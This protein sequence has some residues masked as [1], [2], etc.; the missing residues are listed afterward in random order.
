MFEIPKEHLR[1]LIDEFAS[2]AKF[3]M[4]SDDEAA[5]T[6]KINAAVVEELKGK[7][8]FLPLT[9]VAEA[10]MS[11]SKGELGGTTR[12][13]FRNVYTWLKAV[14]EKNQ[15]LFAEEKSRKDDQIKADSERAF[16]QSQKRNS[17]YGTAFYRKMQ[18]CYERLLT[19]QEYDSCSLDKIV[20]LMEKGY[21]AD[22]ITPKMIL[23]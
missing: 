15:K 23:K 20:A 12:F 18:W 8:K 13:T 16:R 5:V 10:Y 11:G 17:M 2:I 4:S 1:D 7:F 9:L 21:R 19:E 22:Q 14:E 3:Y 6:A